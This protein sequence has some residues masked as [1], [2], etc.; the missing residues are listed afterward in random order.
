[1]DK[2]MIEKNWIK[3]LY[4]IE[5]WNKYSQG[6]EEAYISYILKY[7]PKEIPEFTY[8]VSDYFRASG[9]QDWVEI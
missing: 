7:L 6:D 5:K 3:E 4:N 1:M 2:N 8:E 9:R